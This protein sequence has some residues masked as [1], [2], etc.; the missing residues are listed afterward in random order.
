VCEAEDIKLGRR[1]ALKFLPPGFV[2]DPSALERFRRG[3]RAAS[4]IDHPNICTI[5]EID[6]H[7]G[8]PFIAMPLLQ[9]QT[10]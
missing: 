1:V 2:D 3:A 4:P 5:Y 7:D 10:P 9:G 8:R 6:E